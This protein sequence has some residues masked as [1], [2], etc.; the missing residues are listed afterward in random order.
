MVCRISNRVAFALC[1]LLTEHAVG[2]WWHEAP[3]GA[4]PSQRWQPAAALPV[5]KQLYTSW[6]LKSAVIS[7]VITRVKAYQVDIFFYYC[8]RQ[9]K[10]PPLG[11]WMDRAVRCWAA[12]PETLMA[13]TGG[14]R[15]HHVL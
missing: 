14:T 7:G 9:G 10:R 8:I 2:L 13:V 15:I 1:L 5:C 12:A 6:G 4:L 3:R 11:A